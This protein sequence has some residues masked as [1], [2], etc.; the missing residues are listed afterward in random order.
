MYNGELIITISIISLLI[1]GLIYK[2]TSLN[3]IKWLIILAYILAIFLIITNSINLSG[4]NA[5]MLMTNQYISIL[6][7]IIILASIPFLSNHLK[8]EYNILL[9]S[10]LIG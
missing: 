8:Y 6:K 4:V 10:S 3:T 7:V 1:Y 9:T 2:S 5:D